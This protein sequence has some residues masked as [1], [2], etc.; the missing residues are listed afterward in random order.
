MATDV[1]HGPSGSDKSFDT[2]EGEGE[3][4]TDP[5]N[6]KNLAIEVRESVGL[7]DDDI[8]DSP[9]PSSAVPRNG[10]TPAQI[11]TTTSKRSMQVNST[12]AAIAAPPPPAK[13]TRIL[14]QPAPRLRATKSNPVQDPAPANQTRVVKQRKKAKSELTDSLSTLPPPNRK[15]A[16]A[17]KIGS[18]PKLLASDVQM[19][20]LPLFSNKNQEWKNRFLPTL[21]SAYYRSVEPFKGSALSSQALAD[22]VQ[23]VINVVYPKVNYRAKTANEPFY[24]LSYN[25][26]NDRRGAIPQQAIEALSSHLKGFKLANDAHDFHVWARRL[27]GP[28]YFAEPTPA[29]CRANRDDPDYTPPSGRLH[30]PFIINLVRNAFSYSKNALVVPG[31][32]PYPVGLFALVMTSLERAAAVVAEDG[33]ISA[34]VKKFSAENYGDQVATYVKAMETITAEQWEDILEEYDIWDANA[35]DLAADASLADVDRLNIFNFESPKKSSF[36]AD[37]IYYVSDNV[38]VAAGDYDT[39]KDSF[40][41]SSVYKIKLVYVELAI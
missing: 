23:Q 3:S 5:H 24:L 1:D 18:I 41:S 33:T 32:S 40:G 31:D 34:T 13:A 38:V 21:F 35:S 10:N 20:N 26:I 2:G 8:E 25:R 4:K 7:G 30:S 29:S 39:F 14:V 22:L 27:D 28:L 36:P 37:L 9:P 11:A 17:P 6:V 16:E 12:V 15:T 19:H